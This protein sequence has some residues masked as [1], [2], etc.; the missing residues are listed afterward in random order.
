MKKFL[1]LGGIFPKEIKKIEQ[2]SKGDIQNAANVLQW[3]IIEGIYSNGI[4][5]LTVASAIFV[6]SWPGRYRQLLIK[7]EKKMYDGKEFYFIKFLNLPVLR[8]I[9]RYFQIYKFIKKWIIENRGHDIYII[10]Y[11]AHTP[12]IVALQK[13]KAKYNIIT[14]LIV[15]DLPEF[16]NLNVRIGGIYKFLKYIDIKIQKK[17]LCGIDSFT[18]LTSYMSERFNIYNKP[19][20]VVE[21]MINLNEIVENN[22]VKKDKNDIIKIVYT[23]SMNKRYGVLNLV[24]AMNYI[25]NE[26]IILILCGK[27]DGEKEII[28]AVQKDDRIYYKGQLSRE[29]VLKIQS[30]ATI[31]VNPRS[32]R[33]TYT[34]Y[35]FP[36]KNL[37]Y[38]LHGKPVLVFKLKGIPNEYDKVLNYFK[39]E[40][41]VQMAN[42][43]LKICKLS[44][45]KL[46]EMGDNTTNFALKYK[47]NRV[48]TKKII[49]ICLEL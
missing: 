17:T 16:M 38:M 42:D 9:S 20:I 47:N 30:E 4:N 40:D 31:L 32:N 19:F 45:E 7:E 27:G 29:A 37:E 39:S 23:G 2:K 46:K 11:S 10:A 44:S 43:I 28:R 22:F 3:N 14:H 12:F 21:G 48:Q 34:K 33:E 24:E 49:D 26:N 1:F 6:G 25:K 36:S 18:F 41:P 13:L 35:S 15:P 5:D 8:N